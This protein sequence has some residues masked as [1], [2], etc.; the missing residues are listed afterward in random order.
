MNKKL[1]LTFLG[2]LQIKRDDGP[3]EG[4]IS[5]K[6]QALLCYLAVTGR[7]Q[8]R[9]ALTNLLWG[10]MPESKARAN[11]R[12]ALSNLRKLL[13]PYLI[14]TAQTAEFN[15]D[16]MYQLDVELFQQ[17]IEAQ[18][19]TPNQL[20][21]AEQANLLTEAVKLYQ[22]DFLESF[23]VRNAPT[24]EEWQV[25]QQARLRELALQA[26]HLLAAYHTAQKN[27]ATGIDYTQRLLAL[28][29]WREEAHRQMM[30]LLAQSGQR[31]AALAQYQSCRQILLQEFQATPSPETTTLY[32]QI[33]AANTT[34]TH[35]LPTQP[36]P[37]FGRQDELREIKTLLQN[38]DCRLLTLVG[39]GGIGKTRLVLRVAEQNSS[40]LH[41]VCFVP[42]ASVSSVDY[43]ASAIVDALDLSFVGES[44]LAEQ[45]LNYLANKEMLLVLDNFEHLTEGATLI[46]NIL[47][48]AP[49]IKMLVTSRTRLNL[50]EEW[51]FEVGGL[52]VPSGDDFEQPSFNPNQFSSV[53]LFIQ[54]ARRVRH[55]FAPSQEE[56]GHIV[57]ICRLVGGMPLAIELASSWLRS[58]SCYEIADEIGHNLD[59]LTTSLQNVPERHRSLRV[60][61]DQSWAILTKQEQDVFKRLTVFHGGFTYQAA[62]EITGATR[63][64]LSALVDKSLLGWNSIGRY[65]MHELLHQYGTEKLE[66]SP[67]IKQKTRTQHSRYYLAFVRNKE[68]QLKQDNQ[69]KTLAEIGIEIENI[70]AAWQWMVNQQQCKLVD[71]ALEGLYYFYELRGW[72]G[73][74]YQNF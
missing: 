19:G 50:R 63:V 40:Y 21:N 39:T 31:S 59:F 4:F 33:R 72:Y 20:P 9:E 17:Q 42:L 52:T 74:G 43:L 28:D 12:K 24:F 34:R 29:P 47:S 22:G 30:F 26:L 49:Q 16:S 67:R 51:L 8:S 35:N 1:Q 18:P 48:R 14:I 13:A 68:P 64:V 2:G 65:E 25:T 58:M 57:Q 38:P 23:Y 6:V 60:V 3:V 61:F 45:L 62:R 55:H 41:G 32:K 54:T 11:L 56:L 70:R 66:Q 10:D 44:D 15:K 5:T 46:S 73:E 27:Y 69:Q 71:T 37:F 36:T 7:P 53:R